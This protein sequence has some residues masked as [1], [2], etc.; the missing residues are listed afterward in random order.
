MTPFFS[1]TLFGLSARFLFGLRRR[2][3]P[4]A[5]R[6]NR[7]ITHVGGGLAVIDVVRIQV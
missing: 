2:G 3:V 1:A 5:V 4:P 6:H 7:N